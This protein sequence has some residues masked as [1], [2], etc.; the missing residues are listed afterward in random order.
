MKK[1]ARFP[2]IA[3]T[4][5]YY[6]CR[7]TILNAFV[8]SIG[9]AAGTAALIVQVGAIVVGFSLIFAANKFFKRRSRDVDKLMGKD[10]KEEVMSA[11]EKLKTE[12]L[13]EMLKAS[14][15]SIKSLKE[16]IVQLEARGQSRD[17][18]SP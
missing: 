17:E 8:S 6:E 13:C 2:P 3:L 9:N 14:V 12:A 15:D 11:Y 1:L 4:Q 5:A 16:R 7:P 10:D 18:L